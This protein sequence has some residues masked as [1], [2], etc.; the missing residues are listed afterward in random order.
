MTEDC[1]KNKK[2]TII[3]IDV[4]GRAVGLMIKMYGKKHL[5]YNP[6]LHFLSPEP[7]DYFD[8]N[9]LL[10]DF[11]REQ[12]WLCEK[13]KRNSGRC[14]YVDDQ[15]WRGRTEKDLQDLS[16]AVCGEKIDYIYM[17]DRNEAPIPSWHSRKEY[18]GV[19]PVLS[20]VS[21]KPEFFEQKKINSFRKKLVEI[22]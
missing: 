20:F 2:E 6:E 8:A 7:L 4:S 1:K 12:P 14:V 5:K 15:R 19:W 16:F 22:I 13:M 21:E 3:A 9:V 18:V 11:Q 10:R 17:T